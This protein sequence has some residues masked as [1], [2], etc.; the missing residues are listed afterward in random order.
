MTNAE[1]LEKLNASAD[2]KYRVFNQKIVNTQYPMLGVRAPVLQQTAKQIAADESGYSEFF[3]TFPQDTFETVLLYG[4]TLAKSKLPLERKFDY[5]DSLLPR[6]DNW[7]HVDMIVSAFTELKKEKNRDAFLLR[8]EKLKE[9]STFEKRTLA[10]FLMDFCL[11]EEFL[12]RV[13]ALYKE[14]QGEEY[15]VNMAVAWGLS[16]ALVKFFEPTLA[17]LRSGDFIDDVVYK[18]A[19]KGRD[20]RRLTPEQKALLPRKQA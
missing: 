16:V 8:Y 1:I 7:A 9:G 2:E 15:Y 18:A 3:D 6:F 10:V 4:L 14:L 20:S 17:A 5:F 11:T 19:Q 13:F 12:P